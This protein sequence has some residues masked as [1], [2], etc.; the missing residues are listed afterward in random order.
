MLMDY[1]DS[2]L[3][4]AIIILAISL[5]FKDDLF[6]KIDI[7]YQ[8]KGENQKKEPRN[9]KEGLITLFC[10]SCV[11]ILRTIIALIIFLMAVITDEVFINI[12]KNNENQK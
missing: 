7:Y 8:I 3:I 1:F 12:F 6:H 5:I 2:V 4:Y 10:F 9:I 11:P